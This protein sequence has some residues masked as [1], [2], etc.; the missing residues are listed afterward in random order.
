MNGFFVLDLHARHY[1]HEHIPG[2]NKYVHLLGVG[3]I[4][5]IGTL[6]LKKLS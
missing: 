6:H 4:L 1:L 5:C 3:Q 2:I